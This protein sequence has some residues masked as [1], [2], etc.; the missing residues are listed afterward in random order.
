M[1]ATTKIKYRDVKN[2]ILAR[3]QDKQWPPGHTLPSE[4]SLAE[5]LGCSRA[6]VSRALNQLA[7]EGIIVRKRRAG[8]R[9][10]TF[11]TKQLR[12][13]FDCANMEA[14]TKGAVYRY[15]LESRDIKKVPKLARGR[16]DKVPEG[17][18]L[19]LQCVHYQDE[20]PFQLEECWINLATLPDAVEQSFEQ[21]APIAWLLSENPL[22]VGEVNYSASRADRQQAKFLKIRIGEPVLNKYC[23]VTLNQDLLAL[24]RFSYR[25]SYSLGGRF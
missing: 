5:T 8:S 12:F 9:V 1:T 22:C 16:L 3:I 11:P 19:L 2:H 4:I 6:T 15:E 17:L 20:E 23:A 10:N 14:D 13:N 24:S 21:I 25:T 7:E 18:G